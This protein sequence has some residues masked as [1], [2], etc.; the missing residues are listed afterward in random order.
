MLDHVSRYFEEAPLVLDRDERA[1]GTIVIGDLERFGERAQRLDITLNG[2]IAEHE[3]RSV[4]WR[5]AHCGVAGNE[6]RNP[7]LCFDTV[8]KK[9]DD[10]DVQVG[11]VEVSS[12]AEV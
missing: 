11:S 6:E 12:N 7:Y 3:E 5:L 2:H 4:H 8:R 9:I 10:F 1:L